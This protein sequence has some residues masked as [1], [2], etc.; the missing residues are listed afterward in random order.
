M[1]NCLKPTLKK[2]K[3]TRGAV[4]VVVKILPVPQT[5]MRKT[6]PS[7]CLPKFR[8]TSDPHLSTFTSK[9]MA[10]AK[11]KASN[12]HFTNKCFY[13]IYGRSIKWRQSTNQEYF[14][15]SLV[16]KQYI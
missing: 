2:K 15:S 13:T 11:L 12:Q 10:T 14:Y 3:K 8:F 1:Q 5:S 16:K 4:L 9:Q 6:T 7:K